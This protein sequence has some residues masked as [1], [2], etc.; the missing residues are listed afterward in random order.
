MVNLV[1]TSTNSLTA[2]WTSS[3]READPSMVQRF[4]DSL[5]APPSSPGLTPVA[6][7]L[8]QQSLQAPSADSPLATDDELA[9]LPESE[10]ARIREQWGEDDAGAH[11]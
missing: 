5:R 2:P 8:R 10:L 3:S 6:A 4:E 11:D 9:R 1:P 7:P